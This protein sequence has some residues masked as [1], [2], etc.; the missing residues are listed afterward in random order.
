MTTLNLELK[1]TLHDEVTCHGL[2]IIQEDPAISPLALIETENIIYRIKKPM[3]DIKA[4]RNAIR[5]PNIV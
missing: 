4:N 5:R 3:A 2:K 1:L